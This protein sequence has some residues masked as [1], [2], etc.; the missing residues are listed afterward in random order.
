MNQTRWIRIGVIA[1]ILYF[2]LALTGA[3][4]PTDGRATTYR[5]HVVETRQLLVV[6]ACL[7]PFLVPSLLMF[8]AAVRRTLYRC[9]QYLSELFLSA[10]TVIATLL[11]VTMGLQ[12]AVGFLTGTAAWV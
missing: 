2:L 3:I 5:D 4:A 12:I 11:L 7:F 6:Q 8:S 1:G 9:D 10:Q